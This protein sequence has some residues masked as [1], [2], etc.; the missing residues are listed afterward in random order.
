M[1]NFYKLPIINVIMEKNTMKTITEMRRVAGK[2]LVDKIVE[3]LGRDAAKNWFYSPNNHFNNKS[4]YEICLEGKR[5]FVKDC[6]E[7]AKYCAYV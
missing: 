2:S 4:P 5:S 3:F 7:G 1:R 6:I